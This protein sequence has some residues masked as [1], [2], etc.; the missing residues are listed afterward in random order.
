MDTVRVDTDWL[1]DY[2]TALDRRADEAR[3]V[4]NT[5]RGQQLTEETFGEVGRSMGTPQGYQR[6][7]DALLAQLARADEV[8]TSAATALRQVCEHY[9]GT[10]LDSARIIEKKAGDSDAAR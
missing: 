4:L 6:A 2:A 1:G 5:L 9:R 8:L 7:A 10:D 3:T